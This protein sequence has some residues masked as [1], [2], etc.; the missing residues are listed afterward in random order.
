MVN[1]RCNTLHKKQVKDGEIQY[2]DELKQKIEDLEKRLSE[3]LA[4]D[5]VS[6]LQGKIPTIDEIEQC[7]EVLAAVETQTGRLCKQFEKIDHAQKVRMFIDLMELVRQI[8][9]RCEMF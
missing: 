1:E 5:S 8:I 6:E 4:I 7:C 9:H 3:K 2:S